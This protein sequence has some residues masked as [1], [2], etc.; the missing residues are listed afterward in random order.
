LNYAREPLVGLPGVPRAAEV[1]VLSVAQ[2]GALDVLEKLAV[3]G[4]VRVEGRRGDVLFVNNHAVLHS[5]EGFAVGEGRYLVRMWLRN[6]EMA[7]RLPEELRGG[8]E[9][10]Y[11]KEGE[12]VWNVVD[13]PRVRFRLSERLT[14]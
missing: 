7:W 13:A 5:R 2:R 9:R 1:G 3:E 4:M 8:N 6:G 12:G 10:I 11:G 14:S